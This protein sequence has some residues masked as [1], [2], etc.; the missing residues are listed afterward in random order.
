MNDSPTSSLDWHPGTW[1]KKPAMQQPH[2]A[3]PERLQSAIERLRRLPPLV[4]SWEIE[5]LKQQL[6]T[7]DAGQAFLLQSGDCCE[8]LD[9]CSTETIVRN[10][11]VLMQMSFVLIYGSMRKIVRVGRFAGQYAKPRSAD[12]ETRDGVTL[13]V[14]RGDIVNRN[15]FTAA[16]REPDPEL[17]L[18]GY[19]RAAL[20]LNF[21]RSLIG[22][23]FADLHHPENWELDFPTHSARERD[24]LDMVHSITRSMQFM[25]TVMS[26][27]FRESYGVEIFSSHE[28]LHLSYEEAQTRKVPR[29]D[30]WY[31]LSTHLPWVGYR[32]NAIGGAHVE[33]F[34]GLEN[35][36]GVKVGAATS[37]EQLRD[38]CRLLNPNNT[39][40]KMVLI[41]RFGTDQIANYLP[42]LIEVVRREKIR[43]IWS[44]DPMH[45]NTYVTEKGIKTRDFTSIYNELVAAFEIHASLGNGLGG[46][47]LE[48]TGD[49]VTE[50]VGGA[51]QLAE[52]DL[53]RAYK[54]P[55]D[56]R[57]N[58]DQAMELAFLMS[59]KIAP[60]R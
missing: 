19:E 13:P 48:V 41:H 25:E 60:K 30:G 59:E 17:L 40:G 54:S 53:Q 39:P 20:T 58:Y 27:N 32:T 7:V 14:F 34:R 1:R 3:D 16:E 57:L 42:P 36:I 33:Y 29:R 2:Y 45:G 4:T 12:F 49:N 51:T 5:S 46:V 38:L 50:C 6:A 15:G 37:P 18:R 8:S 43:A 23:G 24:Y 28:A 11:K 35:P 22:G 26:T 10:L 56:P 52:V 55:V 47:H 31:N 9:D 21:V 44:C